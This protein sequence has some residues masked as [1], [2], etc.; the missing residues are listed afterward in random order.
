MIAGL[1]VNNEAKGEQEYK[2]CRNCFGLPFL[3][4]KT[5]LGKAD[6]NCGLHGEHKKCL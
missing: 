2:V 1:S 5:L 6:V 4:W 3:D